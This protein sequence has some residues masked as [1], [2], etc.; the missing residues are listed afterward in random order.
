MQTIEQPK[1][2]VVKPV[3]SVEQALQTF[4][5]YQDLAKKI[6]TPEDFQDI[7]GK[8][9]KKKSFWRKIQRMFNVSLEILK[10]ECIRNEKGFTYLFTVRATAPNGVICDGT[11]AC[12]STEKGLPKTEHNARAIA[13][14]RAKNRAISDLCGLGEVSAEEIDGED[15][16]VPPNNGPKPPNKTIVEPE[17]IQK[18]RNVRAIVSIEDQK[19]IDATIE[20][21]KNKKMPVDNAA[22][23]FNELW[24]KYKGAA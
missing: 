11:G 5:D 21:W 3:L 13:E 6:G 16:N 1:D 14:T 24:K 15:D 19:I 10:E 20:G 9:Y 17:S 2:L 22:N 23:L 18:L 4:R 12:S 8:Q 7:Q